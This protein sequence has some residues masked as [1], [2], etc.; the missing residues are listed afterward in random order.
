MCGAPPGAEDAGLRPVLVAH[1][2]EKQL[3]LRTRGDVNMPDS[4]P[5]LELAGGQP[6]FLPIMLVAAA[7][8]PRVLIVNMPGI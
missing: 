7:V 4:L 1:D 6:L 8:K 3:R 2:A 5:G